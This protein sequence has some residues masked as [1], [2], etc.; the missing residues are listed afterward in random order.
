MGRPI[1]SNIPYDLDEIALASLVSNLENPNQDALLT[2]QTLDEG[3]DFSIWNATNF[4]GNLALTDA[5][6]LGLH[7][8]RLISLLGQYSRD[9][10]FYLGASEGR[11]YELKQPRHSSASCAATWNPGLFLCYL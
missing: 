5:K 6:W 4:H 7:L 8:S 2:S 3:V 1:L 11:V 9:D 10:S